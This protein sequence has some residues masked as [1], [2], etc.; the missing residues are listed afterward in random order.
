MFDNF[1]VVCLV[2]W[3][4]LCSAATSMKE[5][6]IAKRGFFDVGSENFRNFGN[7]GN[8][9]NFGNG[10]NS[11]ESSFQ[12]NALTAPFNPSFYSSASFPSVHSFGGYA[13]AQ[14]DVTFSASGGNIHQHFAVPTQIRTV[15]QN[16]AVPYERHIPIDNPIYTPIERQI[17]IEN[18]VPIVKYVTQPFPVHVEQPIPVPVVKQ[19]HVPQPYKHKVRV[20]VQRVIVENATPQNDYLPPSPSQSYGSPPQTYSVS[21]PI[22]KFGPQ[23]FSAPASS[24]NFGPPPQTLTSPKPN[25]SYIPPVQSHGT[26]HLTPPATSYGVPEPQGYH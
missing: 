11:F 2:S 9:G 12:Q 13:P 24:Q 26:S 10:H 5:K 17:P 1:Q 4:S 20:V 14:P 19:I 7:V 16:V 22:E 15:V 8:V 18:P 3:V 23:T 21:E 25:H 6:N